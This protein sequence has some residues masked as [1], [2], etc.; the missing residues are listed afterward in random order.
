MSVGK[1]GWFQEP[2]K[3]PLVFCASLSLQCVYAR[4]AVLGPLCVSSSGLEK[5]RGRLR[6]MRGLYEASR[7]FSHE[8]AVG[9][10]AAL[11]PSLDPWVDAEGMDVGLGMKFFVH[12]FQQKN[13]RR[14]NIQDVVLLSGFVFVC[15]IVF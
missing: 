10:L 3:L 6:K 7:G 8:L 14:F 1:F 12:T 4:Q 9:L 15:S 11:P 5:F 13:A 2:T